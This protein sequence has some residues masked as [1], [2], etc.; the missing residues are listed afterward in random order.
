MFAWPL[1]CW[2]TV[3]KTCMFFKYLLPYIISGPYI[4]WH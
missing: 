2:F 3:Y 1:C 4:K